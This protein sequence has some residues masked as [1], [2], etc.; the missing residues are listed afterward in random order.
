M[1]QR[2]R[3]ELWQGFGN[4]MSRAVELVLTPLLFALLG[5]L[6]DRWLGTG[7]I[8]TVVLGAVALTGLSIRMYY[9]YRETMRAHEA[10]LPGR[11]P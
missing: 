9:G 4:A 3:Q 5:L 6:V 10:R 11:M 7:H 2:D 8:L 1:E